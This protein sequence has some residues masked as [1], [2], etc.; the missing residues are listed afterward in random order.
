MYGDRRPYVLHYFLE[1][2]T[3]EILEI[4]ENNSG[5]D[6]FPVFLRRSVLPKVAQRTG[7][8]TGLKFKKSDCYSPMD[9]RM[10]TYI[11]VLGRDFLL[12]DADTFT[13]DWYMDNLGLR[14]EDLSAV[15]VKEPM[16]S[17]PRPAL[18]PYNGYGTLEDSV[19][20]CLSLVPKPPRRDMHKL[21]NKDK[22]IL[23]FTVRMVET[24]THKHSPTDLARRFVLNYFMMDDSVQI[25]E[26]PVRNNGIAGG[27]FLE[28]QKVYKPESEEI[29]TYMDLYVGSTMQIFNRTFE[30]MEADEYTYTYMENNKHIFIMADHEILLKSLRAQA[31]GKVDAI[32]TALIEH[33]RSGSG[34]LGGE[35]LEAALAAAGLKFT[36]HQAISLKRRLDKDKSGCVNIEEFL[37]L[38]NI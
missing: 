38:L 7:Q 37:E 19:Q 34:V 31:A 17:L 18:P 30:L 32:R 11:N 27:K 4:N 22:I 14:E 6:P 1:D 12:H 9:F 25:F 29:Y 15:E 33:D 24:E 10:G 35:E 8:T 23:R 20:N 3:V 13:K 26:P 36:R 5:R 16:T 21:M 2:D 28:R